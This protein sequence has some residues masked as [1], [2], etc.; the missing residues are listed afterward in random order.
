[1][2]WRDKLYEII[3]EADTPEGKAFDITLLWAIVFS[4]L[5]VM[6]ES[7]PH[8][9]ARYGNILK[10]IEWGFTVIFTVEYLARIIAVR[11]PGRYIFSFLGMIDLIALLPS[12]LSLFFLGSQYFLVIRTVRLL[13]IF[14][15]FKLSR[16]LGEA[17]TLSRAL[18]ASR[19]KIIVFLGV[20]L[21]IVMISGTLMYLVEGP[22]NGFTSIPISIYWAIV[23]LT[24]VGYGDISPQTALGQTLASFIMIMGYGIIAVPT[25]IVTSELS[26]ANARKASTQT[27]PTC[28]LQDHETDAIYCKHCGT[29]L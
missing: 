17:D 27:C 20:V 11:Y 22:E 19:H 18:Q 8:I 16:F 29:M 4:V 3:F 10:A 6:L 15:I 24:T 2:S 14:R 7:V 9:Q 28:L 21:S 26:R 12:Y 25:G 1:M 23:T 13:R 5:A